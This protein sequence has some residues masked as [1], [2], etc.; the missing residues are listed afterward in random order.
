MSEAA[1]PAP[2]QDPSKIS[3]QFN[4][5]TITGI[6][7]QGISW[8]WVVEDRSTIEV[9]LAGAKVIRV[10]GSRQ[11][12]ATVSLMPGYSTDMCRI[13]SEIPTVASL[14]YSDASNATP[15]QY[16]LSDALVMRVPPAD[17]F[18]ENVEPVEVVFE[19]TMLPSES[20]AP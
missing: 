7:P 3:L 9:G 1:L 17:P 5:F 4:G 13:W 12:R 19:G 18:T 10:T 11:A 6:G 14:S 8:A 20:E 16:V 15:K 2:V